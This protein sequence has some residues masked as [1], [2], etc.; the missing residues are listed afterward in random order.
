MT[1]PQD[2]QTNDSRTNDSRTENSAADEPAAALARTNAVLAEWAARSAADSAS[3]IARLERM[4]Y[5]V[6]GK[7]EEEIA[8]VLKHPPTRSPAA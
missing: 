8:E 7:S 5:A 2:S 1:Q 4:G 6:E 3:L